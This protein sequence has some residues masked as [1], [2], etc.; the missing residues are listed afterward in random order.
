MK[1]DKCGNEVSENLKIC[2]SCGNILSKE[3]K[4]EAYKNVNVS[5]TRLKIEEDTSFIQKKKFHIPFIGKIIIL[6][7]IAVIAY[8]VYK[9][10]M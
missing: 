3:A 4:N 5:A 1:C 10:F 2:P 6:I 8:Y 7:I 9:N